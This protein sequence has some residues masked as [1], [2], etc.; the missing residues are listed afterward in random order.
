MTMG[1]EKLKRYRLFKQ[2]IMTV[3]FLIILIGGWWF[4]LLGYLI[5]LCVLLGILIAISK[6]RKWCDWLCPRGSFYDFLI[7]PF[8]PRK[9]IPAFFKGY[10]LRIGF[11]T[12]FMVMVT[13]QLIL[14]WPDPIKIG[15][16]FITLLTITTGIG[17]ILA[18]FLHPRTWCRFCPVG[19]MA[20]WIGDGK[21]PLKIN[22]DLCEECHS[23]AKICPINVKPALY[24]SEGSKVVGDY[25]CLKCDLCV[26]WCPKG[27]LVL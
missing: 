15:A 23:C 26:K 16:F 5:P 22:S 20:K 13:T 18:F 27:A 8:T 19:S 1:L 21:L 3:V 2:A 7:K 14:R 24:K 17:I 6:G 25:D 4:P 11:L 12:F 10:P 9:D